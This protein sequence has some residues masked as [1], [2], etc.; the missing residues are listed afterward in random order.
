MD[1]IFPSILIVEPTLLLM[2]K[3]FG[4]SLAIDPAKNKERMVLN[5]NAFSWYFFILILLPKFVCIA[6]GW[7]Y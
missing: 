1:F 2:I 6:Y 4:I 7:K 5:K 3:V